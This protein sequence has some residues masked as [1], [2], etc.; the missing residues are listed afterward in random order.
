MLSVS[1][2]TR[3]IHGREMGQSVVKVYALAEGDFGIWQKPKD[4]TMLPRLVPSG[5]DSAQRNGR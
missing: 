4:G 1:V 5:A 2:E 3:R